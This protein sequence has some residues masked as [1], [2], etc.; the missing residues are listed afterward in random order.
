MTTINITH[1]ARLHFVDM[2]KRYHQPAVTIFL[3]PSGCNG[4]KYD[5]QFITGDESAIHFGLTPGFD[6]FID[7]KSAALMDGT[8]IDYVR[9]GLSAKLVYEN[10]FAKGSCGCG[11]SFNF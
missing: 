6:L 9:D 1:A 7:S 11:E 4:F 10:P 8:T 5:Y 2:M 3:K